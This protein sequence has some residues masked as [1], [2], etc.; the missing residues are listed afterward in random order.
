MSEELPHFQYHPAPLLT[1]AVEASSV[2][3]ACCQRARGFIYVGPVSGEED[4]DEVLC[5]WCIADG[6]AAEKLG[7]SFADDSPLEDAGLAEAIIEQV[8]LRTPSYTSWQ[9]EEWLTHCEDAC[10]FHGDASASDV[11][12]AS[13]ATKREWRERC[14]MTED[15]W[16][17]ITASYAPGGSPAFYKFLCRHCK[18]VLLGW[19]CS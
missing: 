16:A 19:D 11:A 4:L 14:E 5:P 7:A 1:G 10:E 3:C 18:T 17:D 12:N 9:Q 6:S 8:H 15:D 13:D 2:T